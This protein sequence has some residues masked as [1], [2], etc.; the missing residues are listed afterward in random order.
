MAASTE[1][2]NGPMYGIMFNTAHKNAMITALGIPKSLK[3]L[4]IK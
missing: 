1:A 2:I 4:G 3:L